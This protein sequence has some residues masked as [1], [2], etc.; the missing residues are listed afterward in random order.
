M[1]LFEWNFNNS[2]NKNRTGLKVEGLNEI[3]YD[4][5]LRLSCLNTMEVVQGFGFLC[6]HPH[7]SRFFY[8]L[9]STVHEMHDNKDVFMSFR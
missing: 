5:H 6:D 8:R 3:V 4:K 2:N 1:E 9:Q 7:E